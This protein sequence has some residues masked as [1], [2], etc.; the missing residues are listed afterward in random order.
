MQQKFYF[1]LKI[2]QTSVS[3][4]DK[5]K[6]K[7]HH[8]PSTEDSAIFPDFYAKDPDPLKHNEL[9]TKIYNCVSNRCILFSGKR[10]PEYSDPYNLRNQIPRLVK[11]VIKA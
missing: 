6:A 7:T 5:F 10:T 11:L 1:E 8:A 9:F 4:L 3:Y 2:E